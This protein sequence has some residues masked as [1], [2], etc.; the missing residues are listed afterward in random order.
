[1]GEPC[2]F[3]RPAETDFG[4]RASWLRRS[5]WN[6]RLGKFAKAGR[7]RR[8]ARRVCSPEY[9]E[10]EQERESGW[11]GDA[12]GLALAL[13]GEVGVVHGVGLRGG[14]GTAGAEPDEAQFEGVGE[15]RGA[16]QGLGVVEAVGLE[17]EVGLH[18]QQVEIGI[19]K[20]RRAL[21]QFAEVEVEENCEALPGSE[22]EAADLIAV[23]PQ[24]LAGR[25][26]GDIGGG[27]EDR[28]RAARRRKREQENRQKSGEAGRKDRS[29]ETAMIAQHSFYLRKFAV[30]RMRR[31]DGWQR[32][33]RSPEKAGCVRIFN[34]TI[35]HVMGVNPGSP[36]VIRGGRALTL[37]GPGPSPNRG[38][39]TVPLS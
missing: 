11:L 32:E 27:K 16:A 13:G 30:S 10:R 1:M 14:G 38:K 23:F 34:A 35:A 25:G 29:G 18:R 15:G 20:R 12:G 22:R 5:I 6:G 26:V 8:H 36:I 37:A 7:L 19:H 33:S 9:R 21:Q 17:R 28:R 39:A 4:A 2:W 31:V 24:V 3:R